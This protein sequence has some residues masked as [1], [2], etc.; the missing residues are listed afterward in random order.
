[1]RAYHVAFAEEIALTPYP[2][3]GCAGTPARTGVHRRPA[4]R[5]R[6]AVALAVLLVA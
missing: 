4:R 2:P 6:L 3:A 5:Y 1:M